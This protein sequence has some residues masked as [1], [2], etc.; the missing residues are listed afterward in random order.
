V[1]EAHHQGRRLEAGDLAARL[2][3]VVDERLP[4]REP[5]APGW[6]SARAQRFMRTS[7]RAVLV[8]V[9]LVKALH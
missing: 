1:P 5:A 8:S 2:A 4:D 9:V 7:R 3:V 6:W